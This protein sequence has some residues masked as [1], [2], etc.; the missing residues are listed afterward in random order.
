M[1]AV[2]SSVVVSRR[3][4]DDPLGFWLSRMRPRSRICYRSDFKQFMTWLNQQPGWVGV[5]PRELLFRQL[6]AEDPFEIVDLLQDFI[7]QRKL[8]KK[9]NERVH[10]A[11]R[12][13]FDHNRVPLPKAKFRVPGFKPPVVPKL[14]LENVREIIQAANLRDRSVI[15]VKW[16]GLLDNEGV[17]YVGQNL[18]DDVVA[19]MKQEAPIIRLNLP[20]RKAQENERSFYTFIGKDAIDALAKYFEH[21]RGWPKPGEAIWIDKFGHPLSV[22]GFGE[23]WL[24]LV[25]RVGFVPAKSGALGSRYGYNAHEMRDIARSLLHVRAKRDDFDQD[26][27]EFILGHT[28]RLDPMKYDKFY[29]DQ[30]YMREQYLIAAKHL[31]ILSMPA[32]EQENAKEMETLR[33]EVA[34]LRGQFETILKTKFASSA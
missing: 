10:A 32:A 19:G 6:G 28:G 5:G 30:D 2:A 20:G 3:V 15:L 26:V 21:Q 12:S 1:A 31:N 24:R 11:V 7:L 18:A 29:L 34:K 4:R 13:F 14:T 23:L 22:Q 33:E 8:R 25:R 17:T 16:M 9:S 27:A